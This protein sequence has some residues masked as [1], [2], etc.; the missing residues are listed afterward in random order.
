MRPASFGRVFT[1]HP[2]EPVL[3]AVANPVADSVTRIYG[4][5]VSINVKQIDKEKRTYLAPNESY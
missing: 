4:T 5:Y 3:V 1:P 2:S